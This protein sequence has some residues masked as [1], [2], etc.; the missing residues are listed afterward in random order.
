MLSYRFILVLPLLSINLPKGS[1]MQRAEWGF[2]SHKLINRMA[3]CTLPDDLMTFYRSNLDYITSHAV[4][5]DK[6]RYAVKGEAIRHYIDLDYWNRL[7]YSN[8]LKDYTYAMIL[9]NRFYIERGEMNLLLFDTITVAQG[10]QDT[11]FFSTELIQSKIAD[12][13][14]I[15]LSDLHSAFLKKMLPV[16]DSELWKVSGDDLKEVIPFIE[17]D[18]IVKIDDRFTAHGMLPYHLERTYNQ[19][20]AAFRS[21]NKTRILR[22]SADIGHYI[23][24]AHV[25]LHTSENYNGQL[26]GQEGIHAF[27]ESRIPELFAEAEFDFVVGPAMYISDLR[28]FIW[29]IIMDSNNE[30]ASVLSTEKKLS[31]ITP[32][33]QQFCFDERQGNVTKI[34]CK[35][36]AKK[37][38]L[39]LDNQVEERMR[40]SIIDLGSVWLSAWIDAGQPDLNFD[41]SRDQTED[42][43]GLDSLIPVN[44]KLKIRDHE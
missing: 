38:H 14:G 42:A 22:L 19:L 6:R 11:V 8:W 44:L 12:V 23:S 40:A 32:P 13:H 35:D 34:Q 2:Y 1:P 24:D 4:D 21:K 3:V 28:S 5:P 20:V 9:T 10:K 43:I 29:K 7:G 26:S 39:L 25:P 17:S 37:Y 16:Y 33:D 41:S 18:D 36:Y 15:P 31:Q 27:W 30:V